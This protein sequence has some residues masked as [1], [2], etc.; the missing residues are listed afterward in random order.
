[1]T[2]SL[3]VS[4]MGPA[5]GTN[6]AW[7][8]RPINPIHARKALRRRVT[9]VVLPCTPSPTLAQPSFGKTHAYP[10][11]ATLFPK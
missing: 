5:T 7:A 8:S 11:G 9:D 1:M 4:G 10:P 2:F 3:T 6:P